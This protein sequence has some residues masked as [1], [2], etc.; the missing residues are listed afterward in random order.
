[1]VPP[2]PSLNFENRDRISLMDPPDAVGLASGLDRDE[3]LAAEDR[4]GGGG[5][6]TG[7]SP[8]PLPPI[9]SPGTE[10]PAPP[11]RST[12]PWFR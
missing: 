7:L 9:P 12:A 1:V 4:D 5:G 2:S 11:S 3:G 8:P 6:R 10:T